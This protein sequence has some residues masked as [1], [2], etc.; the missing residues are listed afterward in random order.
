MRALRFDAAAGGKVSGP[1]D[2]QRYAHA[3]FE[4]GSF[5]RPQSGLEMFADAAVVGHEQHDRVVGQL[6]LVKLVQQAT[7]VL[8]NDIDHGVDAGLAQRQPALPGTC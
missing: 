7:D 6:Q 2:Q 3:A 5:V 4:D 1:T 8:I